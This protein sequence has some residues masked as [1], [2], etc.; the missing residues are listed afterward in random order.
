MLYRRIILLVSCLDA[1][2]CHH[3]IGI[4][5]TKLRDDHNIS[6]CIVGL[7]GTGRACS[8]AAD[9]Q[10]IHVIIDFCKIDL[11]IH[12]TA[13]GM[14][15][16]CQLQRSLL[17]FIRTYFDLCKCIRVII[18]MEFLKKS[19]LLLSGETS[20]LCCHTLRSCSL[21]LFDGFHHIFWIWCIHV[22]RPPYFSIS[23]LL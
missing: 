3:G 9:H 5:D 16:F 21:Y 13:G 6:A 18:R 23:L 15:H 19:V 17:T 2:L 4:T 1:A 20:R 11:L 10:H 22:L 8:A 12:Q 7:N 14:K